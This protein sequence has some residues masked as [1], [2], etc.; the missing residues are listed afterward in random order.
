MPSL[1]RYCIATTAGTRL[2][3][4]RVATPLHRSRSVPHARLACA[5]HDEL[6]ASGADVHC[7]LF[8]VERPRLA[9]P[10]DEVEPIHLAMAREVEN[11]RVPGQRLG[12]IVD[13]RVGVHVGRH[14]GY[15]GQGLFQVPSLE[16]EVERL[17][18]GVLRV[19]E[20]CDDATITRAR[21]DVDATL[22]GLLAGDRDQRVECQEACRISR[23]PLAGEPGVLPGD[24]GDLGVQSE[25]D[26][27]A[28]VASETARGTAPTAP[29]C[30]A[31][32]AGPRASP[33]GR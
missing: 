13:R 26:P 3:T 31:G 5:Q 28:F 25:A 9:L 16:V 30:H 27:Q 18:V 7:E 23:T 17:R 20:Q 6:D 19:G 15:V 12:Q 22:H 29:R 8:G 11:V 10:V 2:A 14:P 33:R 21:I 4:S 24:V 32:R 1:T